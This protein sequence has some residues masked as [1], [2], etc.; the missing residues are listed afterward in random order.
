MIRTRID[1]IQMNWFFLYTNKHL[2]SHEMVQKV[3]FRILQGA[4]QPPSLVLHINSHTTEITCLY[5]VSSS[6][7]PAIR[8]Y[9]QSCWLLLL[10]LS[11][12]R[13]IRYFYTSMVNIKYTPNKN[14]LTTNFPVTTSAYLYVHYFT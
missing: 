1:M 5:V 4:V 2:K 13:L 7:I 9:E 10:Q 6:T 12:W 11:G 14:T 3:R 8:W